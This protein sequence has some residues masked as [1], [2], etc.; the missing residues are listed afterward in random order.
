MLF[1]RC[2]PDNKQLPYFL[3]P[4]DLKFGINENAVNKFIF[5]KF[6]DWDDF[7]CY[8]A[9]S[10]INW[11]TVYGIA[12]IPSCQRSGESEVRRKCYT[13]NLNHG[14]DPGS[15]LRCL[16]LAAC[17]CHSEQFTVWFFTDFGADSRPLLEVPRQ[18]SVLTIQSPVSSF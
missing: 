5:F 6:H 10:C 16:L 8:S 17:C 15:F 18:W 4:H 9:R 13:S 3:I 2:I 12:I 1:Y 7:N 11:P 14:S